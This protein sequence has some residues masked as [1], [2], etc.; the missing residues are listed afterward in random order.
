M[1]VSV[2]GGLMVI[3]AAMLLALTVG[4]ALLGGSASIRGAGAGSLTLTAGALLLGLG[5]GLLAIA[6]IPPL[7][8]RIVRAGLALVALGIATNIATSDASA[9]SV[10]V[11]AYLF[12]G[13]AAWL[14]TIL[15]A[16]GLLRAPGRPRLV[17]LTFV[18]GVVVAL[19]AGVIA[20]EPGTGLAVDGAISRQVLGLVATAG[21]GLMLAGLAGVGLLAVR[22]RIA[23]PRLA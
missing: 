11:Y 2:V 9:S 7:D 19:V 13:L 3:G 17:G 10:L 15:A 16:I 21:A 5:S 6:G 20:N 12:G 1:R 14:G 22:P 8:G 23:S 4:I 18:G